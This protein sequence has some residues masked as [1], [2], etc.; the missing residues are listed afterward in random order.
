V[1]KQVIQAVVVDVDEPDPKLIGRSASPG[2]IL[3]FPELHHHHRGAD[4]GKLLPI[5]RAVIADAG[6]ASIGLRFGVQLLTAT[7]WSEA[8]MP[9]IQ[10]RGGG[11]EG[12]DGDLGR[13]GR[14]GRDG[15]GLV[16][17]LRGSA[18]DKKSAEVR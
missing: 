18:G 7:R 1:E 5:D 15:L 9:M 12:G 11:H 4:L 13:P 2:G 16:G 14:G 17:I 6:E 3:V 10:I 8:P